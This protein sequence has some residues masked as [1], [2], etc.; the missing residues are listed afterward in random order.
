MTELV[1]FIWCWKWRGR[2][3]P[4]GADGGTRPHPRFDEVS[5]LPPETRADILSLERRIPSFPFY[6]LPLTWL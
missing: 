3:V 5:Y 4:T 2:G 6:F 1:G